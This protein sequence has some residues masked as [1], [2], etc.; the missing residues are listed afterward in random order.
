MSQVVGFFDHE[1]GAAGRSLFRS[2]F[3]NCAPL[4]LS[5]LNLQPSSRALH[6]ETKLPSASASASSSRASAE[7]RHAQPPAGLPFDPDSLGA[8]G[9]EAFMSFW[10]GVGTRELFGIGSSDI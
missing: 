8:Q 6:F 9:V 2:R 3:P 1:R 7:L 4:S 10:T 5:A